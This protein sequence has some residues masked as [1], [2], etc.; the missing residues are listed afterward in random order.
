M[1]NCTFYFLSSFL[2]KKQNIL[3][4]IMMLKIF[5]YLFIYLRLVPVVKLNFRK[6]L[7][8]LGKYL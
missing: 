6:E 5:S 3:A 7:K 8:K 4:I 2:L 1:K